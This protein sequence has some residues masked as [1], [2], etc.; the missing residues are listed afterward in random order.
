VLGAR[1]AIGHEIETPR[2]IDARLNK[3]DRVL[4]RGS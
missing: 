4:I 2:V 3:P 1:A